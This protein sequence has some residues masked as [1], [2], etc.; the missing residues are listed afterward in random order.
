[1]FLAESPHKSL[2]LL[3]ILLL[4]SFSLSLLL[5]PPLLFL[6]VF[7]RHSGM[8]PSTLLYLSRPPPSPFKLFFFFLRCPQCFPCLVSCMLGSLRQHFRA[9]LCR[10]LRWCFCWIVG[11]LVLLFV[12]DYSKSYLLFFFPGRSLDCSQSSQ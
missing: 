10:L 11:F 5:L 1:M 6:F 4:L 7:L 3:V 2:L 8:S 9:C 12:F